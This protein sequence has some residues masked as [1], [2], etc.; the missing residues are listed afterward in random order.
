[1]VIF[2][3]GSLFS[4]IPDLITCLSIRIQLMSIL[5]SDS[6]NCME[7]DIK[8]LTSHIEVYQSMMKSASAF[9]RVCTDDCARAPLFTQWVLES[10]PCEGDGVITREYLA[11][12][13]TVVPALGPN[14][15]FSC[16]RCA[17][18]SSGA[19]VAPTSA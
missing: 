17:S 1:M 9:R 18:A 4:A 15:D 6:F 14:D 8:S 3:I 13:T 10:I 7:A 5:G 16:L 11:S 12:P 19:T 2:V